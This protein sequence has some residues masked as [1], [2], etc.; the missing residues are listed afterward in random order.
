MRKE[1]TRKYLYFLNSLKAKIDNKEVNSMNKICRLYR[2]SNSWVNF[3][4]KNGI[5]YK[6]AGFYHWN[7]K[8]PVSIKILDKYRDFKNE[9][10]KKNTAL[11]SN[12]QTKIVFDKKEIK[13]SVDKFKPIK[14]EQKLGV[15]RKF[16]RWL[17]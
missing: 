11:K 7:E 4:L 9:Q 2:V 8:I 1:T 10:Y 13:K 14:T 15:I 17:W 12:N 5:I 6:I 16:L 3:L